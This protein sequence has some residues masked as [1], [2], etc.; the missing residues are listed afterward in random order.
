MGQFFGLDVVACNGGQ[1]IKDRWAQRI[2][3]APG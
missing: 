2:R 3:Q 1:A